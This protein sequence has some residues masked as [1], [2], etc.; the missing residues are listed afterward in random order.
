MSHVSD[1]NKLMEEA[2]E[3]LRKE[4]RSLR[5]GRVNPAMLDSVMVECYGTQMVLKSAAT[6]SVRERNLII[7]PFD[8]M[9]LSAIASSIEKSPIGLQA[10]V[11]GKEY[12]RVPVPAMDESIRKEIAKQAKQK[13][14]EAKISIRNVRRDINNR[15]KKEKESSVITEDDLKRAEKQIQE[16][17]DKYC[18]ETDTIYEEKE[19]DIFLV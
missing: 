19:K 18:K 16:A 8:T 3:H 14:E 1:A 9:Q 17:T 10:I 5:S 6:V 13:K 15:L 4:Y 11:E 2:V 7:T 12:V